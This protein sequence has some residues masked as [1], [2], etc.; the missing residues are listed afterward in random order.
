MLIASSFFSSLQTWL[1]Q[2]RRSIVA[3]FSTD[4]SANELEDN[5]S[6]L[7]T[8]ARYQLFDQL[9]QLPSHPS[10][11]EQLTADFDLI[12]KNWRVSQDSIDDWATGCNRNVWIV[13]S[14]SVANLAN[15]ID[16]FLQSIID[17]EAAQ[18]PTYQGLPIQVAPAAAR[19]DGQSLQQQLGSKESSERDRE[20]VVIPCLEQYFLR[21]VDGLEGIDL[22]KERLI[23]DSSRFWILGLGYVGWKYLQ[24]IVALDTYA[25]KVTHL[26]PL[27]GE[28]LSAWID[29]IVSNLDIRFE[30][31]S[32]SSKLPS[33]KINWRELY[34]NALSDESEG[35]DTVAI[36]L[37]LN[38]LQVVDRSGDA[39]AAEENESN[40][41]Q[42]YQLQAKTPRCPSIPALDG[43]D[44]YLLYSLLLHCWLTKQELAE[45]LGQT[46]YQIERQLQTLRKTGVIEQQQQTLRLNPVYYPTVRTKLAGDNFAL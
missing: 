9:K 11:T 31:S 8:L 37:F 39:K 19:S 17:D 23:A 26:R 2:R 42:G 13:V 29:P 33:S 10:Y 7:P 14:P 3:Q 24:A 40:R 36:Q 38:S 15:V 6:Q 21:S 20:I 46:P 18:V 22:L 45:S 25:Q 35:T 12:F 27:S 16:A 43:E 28:Q 34:F 41:I 5:L 32:L 44:I 1:R 4:R 30:S